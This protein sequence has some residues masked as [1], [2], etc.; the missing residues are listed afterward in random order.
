MRLVFSSLILCLLW[1]TPIVSQTKTDRD[2]AELVGPVKSVEAYLIDF[3]MKNGTIVE[4]KR[5]PWH[6]TTY[7]PEGNISEKVSYDHT[8]AITAKYIHTYDATGR[9][10]GYEEY[11]AT[12]DKNLTIPRRHVYTLGEEGRRVEY[13]VF[14]SDESVGT[15]FLYKYDAKGN[16]TEEQ[17]YAHT[18]QLGGKSLYIFDEKGNQTSQTNYHGDGALNWKN[19]SKFDGNGN[20]TEWLQYQGSTLRYK[21]TSSYDSKGRILDKETFEFNGIP[22]SYTS[23]APEPGKVV[24]TYDDEKRT[25]EVATY[26]VNGTLKGKVVYTYD[27]RGNEIGLTMFNGDGSPK[28]LEIQFYDNVHKPGSAFRGTLSGRSLMNIE[29]DSYGNWTKKT[30]F[31]QSEKAGQPQ[32]YSAELRVITYYGALGT[33]GY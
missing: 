5:R 9:S 24:Y 28:N 31:I 3:S 20:R 22:G 6:S 12:L 33:N 32:A 26:E 27:E 16:L 21:I 8:G 11:S 25:K 30:R 23:H 15:R 2:R 1:I 7:N 19:I 17:W 13:I 18:G 4:G 14:E 29:Y 10:I